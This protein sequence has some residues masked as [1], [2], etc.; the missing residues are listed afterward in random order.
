MTL[1]HPVADLTVHTHMHTRLQRVSLKYAFEKPE[2]PHES[3]YL[4]VR[5]SAEHP[6]PPS[7]ASGRTFSHV[8]GTNTSR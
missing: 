5:Y 3:E 2:I 4:E 7:T 1:V 6:A 8:F